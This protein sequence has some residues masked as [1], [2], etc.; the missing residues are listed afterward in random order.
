MWRDS[1]E[2]MT[3][4]SQEKQTETQEDKTNTRALPVLTSACFPA[5]LLLWVGAVKWEKYTLACGLGWIELTRMATEMR[6]SSYS[7]QSWGDNI[8][9]EVCFSFPCA[10][11]PSFYPS[12]C[13]LHS[14]SNQRY[15]RKIKPFWRKKRKEKVFTRLHLPSLSIQA[16]ETEK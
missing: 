10:P 4:D 12:H 13:S 9:T 6:P 7:D 11:L 8:P 16:S 2:S 5:L 14:H 1:R 3:T 15:I